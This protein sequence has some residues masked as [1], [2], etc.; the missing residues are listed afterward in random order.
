[1][2]ILFKIFITISVHVFSW[3]VIH[4]RYKSITVL[5]LGCRYLLHGFGTPYPK[6]FLLKHGTLLWLPSAD[7]TKYA[8]L[9]FTGYI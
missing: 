7:I 9:R 8:N 5:F 2:H 4:E 3:V 6:E 1:M